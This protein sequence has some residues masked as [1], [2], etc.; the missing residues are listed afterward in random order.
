M[1]PS[2]MV[3]YQYDAR[4]VVAAVTGSAFAAGTGAEVILDALY[5]P[6]GGNLSYQQYDFSMLGSAN[7]KFDEY[8]PAELMCIAMP[9]GGSDMVTLKRT[10]A[11]LKTYYDRIVPKTIATSVLGATGATE[12]QWEAATMAQLGDND[13]RLHYRLDSINIKPILH[14]NGP[15]KLYQ[16]RIWLGHRYGHADP[17]GQSASENLYRY[18]WHGQGYA[19]RAIRQASIP[20]V[21][22]WVLVIP[23][24]AGDDVWNDDEFLPAA[25]VNWP[26]LDFLAPD[27]DLMGNMGWTGG[28]ADPWSQITALM[29]QYAIDEGATRAPQHVPQDL[30]IV[31]RRDGL[32][33]RQPRPVEPLVAH[34]NA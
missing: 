28:S 5:V 27:R 11:E 10:R 31:W 29:L 19:S 18:A 30:H 21:V 7:V 34:A 8:M 16:R 14:L 3:S 25:I 13:A 20:C 23:P 26:D 2:L 15:M 9:M 4:N 17:N 22:V 32:Y 33:T 12:A 6:Q 24:T 1:I